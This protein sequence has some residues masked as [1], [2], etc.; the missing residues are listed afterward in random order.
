MR[1]RTC[2][3]DAAHL[4]ALYQQ[5]SA[6]SYDSS[7]RALQQ[8]HHVQSYLEPAAAGS[9]GQV[10]NTQRPRHSSCRRPEARPFVQLSLTRA[11]AAG[12]AVMCCL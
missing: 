6:S 4:P 8:W 1:T 10:S 2:A 11:Q 5:T 7:R 9:A 3:V 12:R